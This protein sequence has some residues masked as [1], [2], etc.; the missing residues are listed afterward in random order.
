LVLF[1]IVRDWRERGKE[2]GTACSRLLLSRWSWVRAARDEI[3]GGIGPESEFEERSRTSKE[4]CKFRLPAKLSMGF[5]NL[6][7]L[8]IRLC[9]GKLVMEVKSPTKF[10]FAVNVRS[11]TL[12]NKENKSLGIVV[13]A[14]DSRWSVVREVRLRN[15]S[16]KAPA[17]ELPS[18]ITC[19]DC[20]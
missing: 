8:M 9:S 5:V 13:M 3:E 6:W 7:F 14:V 15:E 11:V 19:R 16:G 20:S 12:V 4:L 17:G 10:P 2:P 18:P 1:E